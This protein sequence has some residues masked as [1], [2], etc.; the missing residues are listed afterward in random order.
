MDHSPYA[1]VLRLMSTE[2]H[3]LLQELGAGVAIHWTWQL[4]NRLISTKTNY[5]AHSLLSRALSCSDAPDMNA[6]VR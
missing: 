3:L 6:G 1:C 2:Y 4:K 5:F